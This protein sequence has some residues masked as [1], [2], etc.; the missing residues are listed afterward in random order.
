[1]TTWYGHLWTSNHGIR[2]DGAW[3]AELGHLTPLHLRAGLMEIKKL[4]LSNPPSLPYFL[5]LC[6]A[7]S[8]PQPPV[9]APAPGP[10]TERT[11]IFRFWLRM[12]CS[13]YIPSW[14]EAEKAYK[15]DGV[16]A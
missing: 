9:P 2:D 11:K 10:E 4:G 13:G 7:Y 14:E 6:E 15:M 3:L 1:M 8:P 5:K 16:V 12:S